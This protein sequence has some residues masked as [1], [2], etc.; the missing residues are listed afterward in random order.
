MLTVFTHLRQMET[1]LRRLEQE[2]GKEENFSNEA[3]I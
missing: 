2:M 3:I 1:K